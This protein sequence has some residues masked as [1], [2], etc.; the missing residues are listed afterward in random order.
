MNR[1][2]V[3]CFGKL[4]AF[5]A[6]VVKVGEGEAEPRRGGLGVKEMA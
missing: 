6:L 5:Q 3:R 2:I 1:R 4:V